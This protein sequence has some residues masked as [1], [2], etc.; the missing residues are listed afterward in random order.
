MIGKEFK[1]GDK[2]YMISFHL[3]DDKE[4]M[5]EKEVTIVSVG[6]KYVTV[7]PCRYRFVEVSAKFPVYGILV[8]EYSIVTSK[9]TLL[10]LSPKEVRNVK[11]WLVHYEYIINKSQYT[12]RELSLQQLG[13]MHQ[14]L[15][16]DRQAP[17]ITYGNT[18]LA[19]HTDAGKIHAKIMPDKEYKGISLLF[20]DKGQPGAI[21]EYDPYEKKI[22]LRVYGKEDPDGDPVAI[23]DL[24]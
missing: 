2:V 4:E 23:Y 13:A 7:E 21:L 15:E 14:I 10:C 24:N 22:R 9:Y 5:E 8:S 3:R 18:C 16:G 6:R 17:E 20:D 1:K 11:E 19:V 12:Y